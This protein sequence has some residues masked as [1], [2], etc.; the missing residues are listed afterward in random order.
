MNILIV[1]DHT[2]VVNGIVNG[3]SWNLIGITN[4]FTAFNAF[5]AK[6][7][8]KEQRIDIMLCDIEMPLESGIHLLHWIRQEDFDLECIFL[9]AH[10]EFEYAKEA[11]REG[12]FDYIVQPAPYEVV[13]KV[14]A[15]AVVKMMEKSRH[16]KVF[17]YGQVMM[18]KREILKTTI[19]GDIINGTI[20]EKVYE[21]YRKAVTMPGWSQKCYS[22]LVQIHPGKENVEDFGNHLMQF[23]VT[24]VSKEL[25]SYY[26]QDIV[27]YPISEFLYFILVF[28]PNGYKM[29]NEGFVRQVVA[30]NKNL[31]EY[32]N[33]NISCY[34]TNLI[35]PSSLKISYDQLI[36]MKEKNITC[37]TGVF[38]EGNMESD[39]DNKQYQ[40]TFLN[41]WKQYLSTN[42]VDTVRDEMKQYLNELADKGQLNYNI[43][44]HFHID[45]IRI[46][47]DS[48]EEYKVQPHEVMK[49]IMNL[50]LYRDAVKSLNGMIRFVD[51]IMNLVMEKSDNKHQVNLTE[52]VEAFIHDNIG[53]DLKRA[54]IA[55]A[56][57]L[58]PDYLARIFKKD[59]GVTIG[60]YIIREKMDVAKN[61]IL[62]TALPI[63]L[64]ASRVGY[65][66]FSHFSHSYKRVHGISPSEERKAL[67]D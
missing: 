32:Y 30:I 34:L 50:D 62:T 67:S 63:K 37:K 65:H 58:N 45:L 8:L 18:E 26:E 29:D 11:I 53:K 35:Q 52:V 2:S 56:V 60:E 12:S 39:E 31:S 15:R 59:K 7:V 57:H 17:S 10:A 44:C 23:V 61:L 1:D 22:F 9:T 36:E 64:I 55:M 5:E 24:N 66:N 13:Q 51:E 25:L 43:L 46:V 49:N 28:G 38:C 33:L 3:I 40:L 14:V 20:S 19:L 4:I 27:L 41:R 21:N 42:L 54:D 48:L 47:C 16:K 6:E